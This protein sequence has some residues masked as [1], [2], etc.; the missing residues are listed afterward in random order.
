MQ[1]IIIGD[2]DDKTEREIQLLLNTGYKVVSVTAQHVAASS[3]SSVS[4]IS[5]FDLIVKGK[6]I[7]I[8]EEQS[9]SDVWGS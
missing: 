6:V 3:A 4:S 5:R 9:N 7:F 8:L 2:F 1:K